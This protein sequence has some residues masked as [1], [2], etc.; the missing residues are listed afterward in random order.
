MNG[1]NDSSRLFSRLLATKT[2]TVDVDDLVLY[3]SGKA[4]IEFIDQVEVLLIRSTEARR[5]LIS[6]HNSLE[7]IRA[8]P[9]AEFQGVDETESKTLVAWRKILSIIS[10]LQSQNARLSAGLGNYLA[11]LS[12]LSPYAL[13]RGDAQNVVIQTTGDA[14]L[15]AKVSASSDEQGNL[16]LE[17]DFGSQELP[18]SALVLVQLPVENTMCTVS[19]A[20]LAPKVRITISDLTESSAQELRLSTDLLGIVITQ[21][22]ELLQCSI[23]FAEVQVAPDWLPLMIVK[24]PSVE[25]GKL[26]LGIQVK[27]EDLAQFAV[28]K[29][30]LLYVVDSV[31]QVL[32]EWHFS[33]FRPGKE[34]LEVDWLFEEQT[35]VSPS[36]LSARII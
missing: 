20:D 21:A 7:K 25:N 35:E 30:Q 31:S 15:S 1:D 4:E 8:V 24:Q 6:V 18:D 12:R 23:L 27:G 5:L 9:L 26:T 13:T 16:V 32:G 34:I 2:G 22:K 11:Y 14:S 3:L 19:I 29:F 36:N 28:R 10:S 17:L 33:A